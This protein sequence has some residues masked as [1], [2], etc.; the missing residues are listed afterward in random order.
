MP[1]F[2]IAGK[3][4]DLIAGRRRTVPPSHYI[5][6]S[7]VLYQFPGIKEEN[8]E[9]CSLKGALVFNEGQQNDTR[10][11]VH[12]ALTASQHGAAM[13]NHTEVIGLLTEGGKPGD[14]TYRVVGA[15]VRDV[16]TGEEYPIRAKQ[17]INASGVFSDAVR[18]MAEPDATDIM[19][20]GPGSHLVM[21]DYTSPENMGFLWFTEDGRVLYLL[22]WEGSTL[23]GTTDNKGAP[24]PRPPPPRRPWPRARTTDPRRAACRAASTL[25]VRRRGGGHAVVIDGRRRLH[26]R[27]V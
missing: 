2:Y 1:F 12:I 27:R 9:G 16:F 22:P 17:V 6:A 26:P 4:Y 15:T 21:P 18:K 20:A 5:S 24:P 19:V 25:A 14:P 10:M 23:A 13:L 3:M 11:N 8:K 7:E